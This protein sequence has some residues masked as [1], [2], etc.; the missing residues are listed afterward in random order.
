MHESLYEVKNPQTIAG[1]G[2]CRRF[3]VT[4]NQSTM[5]NLSISAQEIWLPVIGYEGLYEVSNFGNVKALSRPTYKRKQPIPVRKQLDRYGYHYVPLRLNGRTKNVKVHRLVA[6]AFIP[7]PINKSDVNHIDGNKQNNHVS[8]LEWSTVKENVRHA[9]NIG[10]RTMDHLIALSKTKKLGKNANA[11][12]VLQY[13]LDGAFI[14]E[15]SCLW[16]A[17]LSFH[18]KSNITIGKACREG[19]GIAYGFR[20]KYAD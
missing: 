18:K 9:H 15:W 12:R 17:V 8:N 1:S 11:K 5:A 14:R 16:E 19:M 4:T 13:N 7:N 10:L 3:E 6:M 20:W 2:F